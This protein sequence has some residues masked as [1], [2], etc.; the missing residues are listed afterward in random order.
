MSPA[1]KVTVKQDD[2]FDYIFTHGDGSA[3]GNETGEIMQQ[4]TR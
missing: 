4:R 3:E 1:A 2:V